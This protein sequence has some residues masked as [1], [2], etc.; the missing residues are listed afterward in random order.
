MDVFNFKEMVKK[1]METIMNIDEFA[2]IHA[3]DGVEVPIIIDNS[4]LQ[5]NKAK[6]QYSD[7]INTGEILFFVK[8]SDLKFHPAIDQHIV[9]D[10]DEYRV[11]SVDELGLLYEITL[12]GNY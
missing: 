5:E 3:V 4:K 2:T 1:D 6:S 7:G 11:V 9:F 8:V 12:R 10:K